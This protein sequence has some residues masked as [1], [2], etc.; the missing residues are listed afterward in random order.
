[1]TETDLAVW[2]VYEWEC[3]S[4]LVLHACIC[5]ADDGHTYA[6]AGVSLFV[7]ILAFKEERSKGHLGNR[8]ARFVRCV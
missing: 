6:V 3:V 5:R 8:C 1:M 4:F 2:Q 7:C